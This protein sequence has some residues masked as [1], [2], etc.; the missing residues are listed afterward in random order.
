MT[1]LKYQDQLKLKNRR[2]K[3]LKFSAI[4]GGI[5]LVLAGLI[6]LLLF[7]GLFDIRNVSVAGLDNLPKSEIKAQAESWLNGQIL[8][9]KRRSNYWIFRPGRNLETLL[10]NQSV[11]VESL[12]I[13][14]ISRHEFTVY[15]KERQPAGIWCFF[16]NGKCFYYDQTGLAFEETSDSEGFIYTKVIDHQGETDL[17]SQVASDIWVN[18]LSLAAKFLKEGGL[19]A[20]EFIIPENSADEFQARVSGGWKILF[21]ASTNIGEQINS[22]L[23]FLKSKPDLGRQT[24]IEYFDLT[25]QD[26]IYYK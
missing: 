21:S 5:F 4:L 10:A 7:A 23:S 2:K 1:L 13:S 11:R 20:A 25:V 12:K 16:K 6:Y 18:S 15:L 17:G 19:D 8:G 3:L 9:I 26:R 14:Q 24:N 22:F